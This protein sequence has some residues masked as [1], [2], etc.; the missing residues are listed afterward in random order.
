MHLI[1]SIKTEYNNF[2]PPSGGF[3]LTSL[4]VKEGIFVNIKV[5]YEMIGGGEKY[6]NRLYKEM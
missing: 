1:S 4:K 6:P 5:I 2:K 3:L